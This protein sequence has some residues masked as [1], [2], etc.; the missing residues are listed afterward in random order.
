MQG[1]PGALGLVANECSSQSA[2][3]SFYSPP[4]AAVHLV[5]TIA[6]CCCRNGEVAHTLI[7][8]SDVVGEHPGKDDLEWLLC[9]VGVLESAAV[10]PVL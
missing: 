5:M 7:R 4:V 2:S 6:A 9:S 1:W 10:K 3:H 8:V